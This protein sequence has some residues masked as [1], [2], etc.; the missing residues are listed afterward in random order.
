LISEACGGKGWFVKNRV[1]LAKAVKEALA[2]KDQT[3]VVNV[4]IAPGGRTKLDFGWMQKTQ[5]A[6]L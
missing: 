3:C 5:K 6:R 2:A 4:M 1:E